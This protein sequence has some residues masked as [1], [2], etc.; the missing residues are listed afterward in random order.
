M[1]R[2][3]VILLLAYLAGNVYILFRG[4]QAFKPGKTGKKVVF[5]LVVALLAALFPALFLQRT[6]LPAA[7]SGAHL[8]YETGSGWLI[9]TLYMVAGLLLA[10]IVLLAGKLFKWKPFAGKPLRTNYRRYS[11]WSIFALVIIIL[12]IGYY[13]YQH[14]STQVFNIV[15]NKPLQSGDKALRVVAVSDVHLGYGTDKRQLQRYVKM[16]NDRQPDLV[17]IGGDLIDS[18]VTPL[19]KERMNEELGRIRAPLGVYMVPGNHE[20]IAGIRESEQFIRTTPVRYLRDSVARLPNGLVIA[21]RDDA[22]NRNRATLAELLKGTSKTAPVILLDHQPRNL[23]EAVK[24]G[25]D[26]Q[27]SGHTHEGQV[28]PVSLWVKK[29]FELSHG[30]RHRGNTRQ[31]V[32]SGLSL[33]GPPFRIGTQSE[34][35]VFNLQFR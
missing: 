33:W 12:S 32:S 30:M 3:L 11:F 29:L 10:D 20:Y 19:R 17:L 9:F 27:F 31:Y 21:G 28:W 5:V 14:P 26:L 7:G 15:I 13:R 2:L 8:L 24:A 6:L 35:V 1:L 22:S 18:D 25:V 16:I 34:L 4:W 23:N